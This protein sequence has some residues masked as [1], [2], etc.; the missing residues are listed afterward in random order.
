[1]AARWGA[2]DEIL[3]ACNMEFFSTNTLD[4][5]KYSD[6]VVYL[7]SSVYLCCMGMSRVLGMM[8]WKSDTWILPL[9]RTIM[10]WLI[11]SSR[12][13]NTDYI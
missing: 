8:R 7:V 12:V 10:A 3:A 1:M 13:E 2:G 9:S 6:T 4:E 11:I 5:V